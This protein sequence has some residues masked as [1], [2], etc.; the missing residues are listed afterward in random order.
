MN[1]R[2]ALT[3]ASVIYL[4]VGIVTFGNAA[5]YFEQSHKNDALDCRARYIHRPD[6]LYVCRLYAPTGAAA[7]MA[8]L[9][10]PFY[11]SYR[12]AQMSA[13]Y[14]STPSFSL[15]PQPNL[16]GYGLDLGKIPDKTRSCSDESA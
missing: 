11:W 15:I 13:N 14:Y 8:F 12:I 1:K 10:W 16:A 3:V 7:A 2:K 6:S 4:I 9:A 5:V